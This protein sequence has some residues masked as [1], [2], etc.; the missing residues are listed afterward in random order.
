MPIFQELDPEIAWKLIEGYEDALAPEAKAQEAFY[1]QFQC[2]RCK[3]PLQKEFDGRHAFSSD[4]LVARALLRCGT[5][6]YLIEP[7]TGLVVDVGNPVKAAEDPYL[8]VRP[9]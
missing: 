3:Q 7:D 2:P 5:C 4:S 9:R 6:D 1:R 8:I